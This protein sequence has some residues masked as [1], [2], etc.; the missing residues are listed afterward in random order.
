MLVIPDTKKVEFCAF[1]CLK[2]E[3]IVAN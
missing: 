3:R 1:V 2:N